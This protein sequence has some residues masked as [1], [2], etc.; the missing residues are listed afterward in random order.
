MTKIAFID[1]EPHEKSFFMKKLPDH[2]LQFVR[3]RDWEKIDPDIEILSVFVDFE[4]T[5]DVI[6][7]FPNLK[8]ITCRSTGFNNIDLDVAKERNIIVANT[9]GYGANSVAEFVFSLILMLSRKM[10]IVQKETDDDDGEVDRISERGFDLN[11]KTI[12]IVGLGAIGR[13]VAKI[14]RGFGMKILAFE[15]YNKDADFAQQYNVD[16]VD[17]LSHLCKE[18]DIVTLHVPY[19][20]ENHHL[21]SNRLLS[22]MKPGT[23]VI[24]TS[25]GELL[26]TLSLARLLKDKKLGGAGLDVIEN[27]E[28][29]TDPKLVL[30]LA[31]TGD[32]R[33]L[34]KLR[35]ALAMLSLER[36][37][38]VIIT[39]HNAF[40]TV[41]ALELINSMTVD[42]INGI[43]T[44]GKVFAVNQ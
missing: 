17:D 4:V 43:L 26:N 42:N 10:N 12:G 13:G 39:N 7:R 20:P 24:N 9:P 28:Y 31:V 1:V 6:D 5:R 11:E 21:L 35:S 44:G 27:E 40:N 36:M 18:S 8:L 25:R 29:L 32:E 33:A 2:E 14:A 34:D 30:D 23:L 16:F 38:N 41:E 19:T 3:D 15:P 22:E 37:P